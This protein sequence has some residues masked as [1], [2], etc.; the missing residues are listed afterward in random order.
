MYRYTNNKF[1]VFTLLIE[2]ELD[3]QVVVLHHD[4]FQLTKLAVVIIVQV[5]NHFGRANIPFA[6]IVE[7]SV[8]RIGFVEGP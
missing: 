8:N 3:Q 7:N 5:G 4:T 1:K 2:W 6:F